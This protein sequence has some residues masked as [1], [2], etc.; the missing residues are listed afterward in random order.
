MSLKSEELRDGFKSFGQSPVR[1]IERSCPKADI[2]KAVAVREQLLGQNDMRRP[3]GQ[4]LHGASLHW[5]TASG[6]CIG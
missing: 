5:Q 2:Q 4:S 3:F 1:N 6:A